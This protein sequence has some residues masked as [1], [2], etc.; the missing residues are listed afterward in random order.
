MY[1][2]TKKTL[3][4]LL[5]LARSAWISWCAVAFC[6]AMANWTC[7][8]FVCTS[9]GFALLDMKKKKSWKKRKTNKQNVLSCLTC[10]GSHL[11]LRV[12]DLFTMPHIAL[13]RAFWGIWALFVGLLSFGVHV[14]LKLKQ[15]K[16]Q[17]NIHSEKRTSR[18][19]DE[20]TYR[21]TGRQTEAK[22]ETSRQ[23]KTNKRTKKKQQRKNS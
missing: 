6:C 18:E 8:V 12:P 16:R 15:K 20:H 4:V 7:I 11:V 22:R 14:R 17:W 13:N 3:N 5:T 21:Q 1:I 19:K 10:G 9:K 23:N 2:L